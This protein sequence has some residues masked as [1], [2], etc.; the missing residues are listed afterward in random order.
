MHGLDWHREAAVSPPGAV[1]EPADTTDAV[2]VIQT[3]ALEKTYNRRNA[4]LRGVDVAIRPGE[5][6]AL[7]GSNGSGKSTLLKCLIGLHPISGGTVTTLGERFERAPSAR[8]RTEMRRRTG[9]VFQ[10]HSLVRRR[11]ALSNVVHGLLGEAGS[12]RAFAQATAPQPWRERALEALTEVGL[13]DKAMERTDSLSGGQQQRVAIARALVRRP[14]LLIADEPAASLD[15][16]AGRD[17]MEL[18]GKLCERHGITLLYTSH[19]MSHAFEFSERVI[20]LRD[21]RIHFDRLSRE[22]DDAELHATFAA[23]TARG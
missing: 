1:T 3:R 9:F 10:N 8:Q 11:S 21:G 22:L 23:G 15:P 6:V 14:H 13:A 17:V 18:F 2:P 4:V 5:R 20:A 19:D 7:I 16:V 12:W